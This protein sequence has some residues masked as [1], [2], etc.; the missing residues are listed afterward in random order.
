MTAQAER[1]VRHPALDELVEGLEATDG[2]L[3]GGANWVQF[4]FEGVLIDANIKAGEARVRIRAYLSLEMRAEATEED[5]LGWVARQPRPA[6]GQV[7]T[8]VEEDDEEGDAVLPRLVFERPIDRLGVA[9]IASDIRWFVRAWEADAIAGPPPRVVFE[10]GT[11]V[12][13]TPQNAWLLM[14]DEE[15]YWSPEALA[16]EREDGSVG[17]Y[18]GLWT[19]P[20]NGEVGDLVLLYY[21]APRKA[22]C[23]VARLASRPF[24]RT[25]LSVGAAR[26]VNSHQWWAYLT[27]PVEIEPIPYPALRE[28]AAGH[29]LL[30]GRSGH[31]LAP[32]T[33]AALPFV[34][35]DPE[36][37][38]DVNAIALVPSGTPTLPD[39]REMTLTDWASIPSGALAL[40]AK[41][42][43]Y[44]VE[45]LVRFIGEAQRFPPIHPTL[46]AEYRVDRGFVD[47]ALCAGDVP[48]LAIEVKLAIRR[49]ASGEW[50]DSPDFLQLERYM[51]HL[52]TPG[53]LIDAHSVVAFRPGARAPEWEVVRTR[54][55]RDDIDTMQEFVFGAAHERSGATAPVPGG[56]LASPPD[57]PSQSEVYMVS[58]PAWVPAGA[59]TQNLPVVALRARSPKTPASEAIPIIDVPLYRTLAESFLGDEACEDVAERLGG[60]LIGPHGVATL[61]GGPLPEERAELHD[62]FG[63]L[64]A[65]RRR[66]LHRR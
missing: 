57:R 47:F 22:A 49:P 7:Q 37:Q 33:I 16:E 29:L 25:D 34:A 35:R 14:G 64:Y 43:E 45:P 41:V 1:P 61:L 59:V 52:G 32:R 66:L 12:A 21:S 9:S 44:L 48:L 26:P 50:P 5:V 20:K 39:P 28:A 36:E 17:I 56:E 31:Y 42:S 10:E 63:S 46:R 24:W 54:A 30:R 23:F 38:S 65:P 19:A 13:I 18:D 60:A 8:L 40:E 53:L 15:S 2:L 27:P 6:S 11:P 51:K 3:D 55:R 4:V 58:L 62:L